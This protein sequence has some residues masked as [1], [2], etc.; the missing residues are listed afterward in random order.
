M[1]TTSEVGAQGETLALRK[2]FTLTAELTDWRSNHEIRQADKEGGGVFDFVKGL[3]LAT[4]LIYILKNKLA[5]YSLDANWGQILDENGEYLSPECDIIIHKGK[6]LDRWNGEG[7][8]H[9]NVMDFRF[10]ELEN[11][12]VVVSCKSYLTSISDKDRRYCQ[13]LKPYLKRKELWLFA[14]CVP[15]GKEKDLDKKARKIGHNKLWYLYSWDEKNLQPEQNR[16]LW[17]RFLDELD[18]IGRTEL[19]RTNRR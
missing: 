6:E 2:I 12:V 5:Q 17:K 7:G 19:R 9:G 13:R 3:R 10:I 4:R 15:I 11:V 18:K 1:P 8:D 14:E 16:P